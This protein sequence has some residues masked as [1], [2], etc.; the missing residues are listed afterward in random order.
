VEAAGPGGALQPTTGSAKGADQSNIYPVGTCL[1]IKD[2]AVSDPVSCTV[3]H[4]YEIVG[5]VDLKSQFPDGFPDDDKQQTALATR[6]GK[7]VSDYTNGFDL[8]KA[9]LGLTWDTVKQ[10]SWNVGSTKVNCKV[11]QKLDDGSG[12]RAITNSL[13]GVGGGAAPT[14][15]TT[16]PPPSG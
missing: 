14:S 12:L 13:K 8:T 2:K 9:K 7:A 16:A 10:E 1:G 5:I 6:C 15:T 11:G 3:A 4:A